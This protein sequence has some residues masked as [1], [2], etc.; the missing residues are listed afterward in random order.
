M[1]SSTSAM[2]HTLEELVGHVDRLQRSLLSTI[3]RWEQGPIS[4]IYRRSA[5][6]PSRDKTEAFMAKDATG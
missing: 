6:H 3:S 2:F 1:Y 5:S 4:Y